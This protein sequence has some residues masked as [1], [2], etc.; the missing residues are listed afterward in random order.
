MLYLLTLSLLISIF[1]P[2]PALAENLDKSFHWNRVEHQYTPSRPISDDDEDTGPNP[3]LAESFRCYYRPS[4]PGRM[5]CDCL[6]KSQRLVAC[7]ELS[8]NTKTHPPK[9]LSHHTVALWCYDYDLDYLYLTIDETL[10]QYCKVPNDIA[11]RLKVSKQPAQFYTE[12]IR[13]RYPCRGNVEPPRDVNDCQTK[14]HQYRRER[15]LTE[16]PR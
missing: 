10:Y 4:S 6:T 8:R 9:D 13:G 5:V 12:N 14:L 1:V 2:E 16:T 11:D 7:D 3:F 15:S